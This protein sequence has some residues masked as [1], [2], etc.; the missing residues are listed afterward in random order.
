M[1]PSSSM[2][3][4]VWTVQMMILAVEKAFMDPIENIDTNNCVLATVSKEINKQELVHQG[5][6]PIRYK[7]NQLIG[8]GNSI[9][10]D[11]RY[12]IIKGST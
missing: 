1:R 10:G 8:I 9:E 4:V 3:A 7:S 12:K 6:A 11:T 2:W 5:Y